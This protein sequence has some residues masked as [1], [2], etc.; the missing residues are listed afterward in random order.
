MARVVP[1]IKALRQEPG[2][3][4]HALISVDTF[5]PAVAAA[6]VEAGANCINDVH[7]FMGQNSYPETPEAWETGAV[8]GKAE[9]FSD[10]AEVFSDEAHQALTVG[11]S[12][13]PQWR[14]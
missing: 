6:A 10:E 4:G 13:T 11:V 3:V 9:V 2:D 12:G 5:R 7:A 8:G 14:G 1:I